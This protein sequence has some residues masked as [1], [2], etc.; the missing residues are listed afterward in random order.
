[1]ETPQ[2]VQVEAGPKP[3]HKQRKHR[4]TPAAATQ[5]SPAGTSFVPRMSRDA[6]VSLLVAMGSRKERLFVQDS[7]ALASVSAQQGAPAQ[8]M[9]QRVMPTVN[10]PAMSDAAQQALFSQL[11][12]VLQGTS[13]SSSIVVAPAASGVPQEQQVPGAAATGV[14]PAVPVNAPQVNK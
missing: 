5:Q 10:L 2:R 1:M 8:D 6:A 3:V 12:D 7:P 14:T 4:V 13:V 9:P 11:L